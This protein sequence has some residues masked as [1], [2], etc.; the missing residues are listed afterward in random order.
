[1]LSRWVKETNVSIQGLNV[2]VDSTAVVRRE[3]TAQRDK[4]SVSLMRLVGEKVEAD[5]AIARALQDED[6]I[7]AN[8]EGA[9][10]LAEYLTARVNT[11]VAS[12]PPKAAEVA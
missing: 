8:P 5:T 4:L 11:F 2:I 6:W 10:T 3:E 12:L 7:K 1:A 9:V